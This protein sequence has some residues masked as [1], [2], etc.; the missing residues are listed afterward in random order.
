VDKATSAL[1]YN[2]AF[3][4]QPTATAPAGQV[5]VTEKLDVKLVDLS[6][7]TVGPISFG[8]TTINHPSGLN[9]FNMVSSINSLLLV[10]IQASLNTSSG[11]MKWTFTSITFNRTPAN[12][13]PSGSY[14]AADGQTTGKQ[15]TDTASL[16]CDANAPINT[17]SWLNTL[18]ADAPVSSASAPTSVTASCDT[19]DIPVTWTESDKGAGVSVYRV[20]IFD[21]GAPFTVW[22]NNVTATSAHYSGSFDRTYGFYAIAV[23]GAPL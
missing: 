10:R 14:C 4:N 12:I 18:D 5:M 8:S 21:N 9:N 20:Y 19:A 13:L 1:T 7:L 22:Q 6:T 11:L 16:V 23:W 2:V 17:P 3:E 15:I